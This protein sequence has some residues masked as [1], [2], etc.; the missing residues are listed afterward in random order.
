MKNIPALE[1]IPL[2]SLKERKLDISAIMYCYRG[3]HRNSYEND[4]SKLE[5]KFICFPKAFHSLVEL[6]PLK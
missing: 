4:F 6:V 2:L 1:F 5:L 3:T